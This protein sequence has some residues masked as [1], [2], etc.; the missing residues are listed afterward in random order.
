MHD[1]KLREEFLR[2]KDPILINLV[3]LTEKWQTESNVQRDMGI[4]DV[5]AQTTSTY[6]AGKNARWQQQ[7]LQDRHQS[8]DACTYCGDR[9]YRNH[10]GKH[11]PA[12]DV[13][14]HECGKIGHYK[15]VCKSKGQPGSPKEGGDAR[16]NLVQVPEVQ[17]WRYK[18]GG[19]YPQ[20][21]CWIKQM[22]Q[23]LL[24]QQ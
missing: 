15:R 19:F 2:Q 23:D 7:Q 3:T 18:T 13:E 24:L 14:C 16:V 9:G 10:A 22:L 1:P 4:D 6:K 12:R 8:L 5:R 11:S 21:W 17:D 20:A